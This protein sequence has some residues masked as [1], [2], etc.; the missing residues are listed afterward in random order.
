M[1]QLFGNCDQ[2]GKYPLNVKSTYQFQIKDG[3]QIKRNNCSI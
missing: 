3:Y 2:T 1:K